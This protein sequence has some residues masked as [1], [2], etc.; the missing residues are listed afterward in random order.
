MWLWC[1][2]CQ[3]T[4]SGHRLKQS[5]KS[6]GFDSSSNA[7]WSRFNFP[8]RT[9]SQRMQMV[10]SRWWCRCFSELRTHSLPC[11]LQ[12]GVIRCSTSNVDSTTILWNPFLKFPHK[13]I[14]FPFSFFYSSVFLPQPLEYRNLHSDLCIITPNLYH[15]ITSH[16]AVSVQW[17]SLGQV[18]VFI[19]RQAITLTWSI[20]SGFKSQLSFSFLFCWSNYCVLKTLEMKRQQC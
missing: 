14:H 2:E 13:E 3:S 15:D 5:L 10:F 17:M 16:D 4:C 8:F 7:L 1:T 20:L 12:R 19:R 6:I 18:L 9:P 11:H